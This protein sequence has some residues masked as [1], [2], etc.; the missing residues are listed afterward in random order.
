MNNAQDADDLL[1]AAG[2]ERPLVNRAMARKIL[3]REAFD[4]KDAPRIGRYYVIERRHVSDAICR[5]LC[6]SSTES[7]IWSVGRA[8]VTSRSSSTA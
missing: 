1:S 5:D 3:S 4:L 6:D 8:E 2:R 7:W